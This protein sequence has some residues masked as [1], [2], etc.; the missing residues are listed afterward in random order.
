MMSSARELIAGAWAATKCLL[1]RDR[2]DLGVLAVA[3]PA[4]VAGLIW[5]SKASWPWFRRHGFT[6][7]AF[8][9]VV[10]GATMLVCL[11]IC[12]AILAVADITMH[13]GADGIVK[14]APFAAFVVGLAFALVILLRVWRRRAF[15]W[16]RFLAF[17][18][19]PL[20]VAGSFSGEAFGKLFQWL[21]RFF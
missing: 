14:F 4:A 19:V 5:L 10:I 20:G 21:A 17:V 18:A 2:V 15:T 7:A 16:A 8:E 12:S 3:M 6:Y 11:W 1:L 13:Q 9:Q